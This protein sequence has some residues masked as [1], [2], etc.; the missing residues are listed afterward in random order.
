MK[1]RDV[2][3]GKENVLWMWERVMWQKQRKVRIYKGM[4]EGVIKQQQRKGRIYT[5]M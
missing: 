3:R 2:S 4:W 1:M 5:G